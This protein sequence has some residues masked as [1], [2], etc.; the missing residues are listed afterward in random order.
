MGM[1]VVLQKPRPEEFDMAGHFLDALRAY[2]NIK[3]GNQ[4]CYRCGG[5]GNAEYYGYRECFICF[6]TGN[7]RHTISFLLTN[8]K[9][10]GG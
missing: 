8:Y 4:P 1:K 2:E 3:N 6:G 7:A 10:R 9:V 5:T